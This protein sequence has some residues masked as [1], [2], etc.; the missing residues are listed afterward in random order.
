MS[1]LSDRRPRAPAPL[2]AVLAAPPLA[3]Q[4]PIRPR[5]RPVRASATR[6][7]RARPSA[8]PTS[9]A[10]DFASSSPCRRRLRRAEQHRRGHRPE[11][12]TP[13]VIN[14]IPVGASTPRTSPSS[15]DAQG[16]FP[17]RRGHQLDLGQRD[18]VRRQPAGD[19]HRGAAGPLRLRLLLP[20][21]V[22]SHYGGNLLRRHRRRQRGHPRDRHRQRVSYDA[23]RLLEHRRRRPSVGRSCV[24]GELWF[25]ASRYHRRVSSAPAAGCHRASLP[26]ASVADASWM[27]AFSDGQYLY[28]AGQDLAAARATVA[29]SSPAVSS[30]VYLHV[31]RSRTASARA[32]APLP[33]RPRALQGLAVDDRRV[34]ARRGGQRHGHASSC[35]TSPTRN[36]KSSASRP[37]PSRHPAERRGLR[38]MASS[39]SP[40][41]AAESVLVYD[42]LPVPTSRPRA[43]DG[44]L[45]DLGHHSRRSRQTPSWSNLV[46]HPG[47]AGRAVELPPPS[48]AA[49]SFQGVAAG[50]RRRRTCACA[51]S[52]AA[53][54]AG[55]ASRHSGAGRHPHGVTDVPA[56]HRRRRRQRRGHATRPA[57]VVVQ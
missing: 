15:Y 30:T 44:S 39:T 25:P 51:A 38:A 34:A 5:H 19:R 45:I 48:P 41:R 4:S 22:S 31:D 8:S 55:S 20:P 43:S 2:T 53:P 42:N 37:G 26:A 1:P 23:A 28:P 21:S 54:G 49:T 24:G 7:P 52:A 57:T 14:E 12:P 40:A 29:C 36:S 27:A 50:A 56:G 9:A 13:F 16:N 32:L 10:M 17:R 3:A 33:R 6:S 47:P 18:P 46:G 11:R 35:S